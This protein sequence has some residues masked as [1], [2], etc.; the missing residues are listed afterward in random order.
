[1][2]PPDTLSLRRE[3]DAH[4]PADPV[5]AEAYPPITLLKLIESRDPEAL[6]AFACR[7]VRRALYD[8]AAKLIT[9][10]SAP[11]ELYDTA[12]NPA[13]DANRIAADPD[14]TAALAAQL[15]AILT[16]AQSRHPQHTGARAETH[17][18][19]NQALSDRLRRLGYIE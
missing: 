3:L 11:A 16:A 17:P 9:V 4:P 7:S 10:D 14:R 18:E 2:A 12:A 13:E 6:E 1:V 8:G 15:G 5:W 19:Q